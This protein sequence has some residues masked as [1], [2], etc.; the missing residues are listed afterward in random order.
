MNL[1]DTLHMYAESE[2]AMKRNHVVLQYSP[3][4]LYTIEADNK[5]PD[6]FRIKNK[7]K[8]KD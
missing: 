2:P 7:P 4:E 6:K 8:V 3:D 1:I 5:I